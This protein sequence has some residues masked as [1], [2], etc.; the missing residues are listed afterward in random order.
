MRSYSEDNIFTQG[1]IYLFRR[2]TR[3]V[4]SIAD[5]PDVRLVR[6][7]ELARAVSQVIGLPI[8]DGMYG[9]VEHTWLWTR[10]LPKEYFEGLSLRAGDLCPGPNILDV[11]SVGSLPMVR[12][13]DGGHAQLPHI[14]WSYRPTR[15]RE[16]INHEIVASLVTAMSVT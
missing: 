8:Q 5:R 9:F 11:Y 6:C 15:A 13:V 7:H 14:G 2:A 10:E 1:E 12:L 3:L 16:D 4:D